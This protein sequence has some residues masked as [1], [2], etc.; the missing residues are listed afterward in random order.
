MGR[1]GSPLSDPLTIVGLT[2]TWGGL[3][4]RLALVLVG[5]GRASGL[6]RVVVVRGVV[7]GWRG[8]LR[9][10]RWRTNVSGTISTNTTWTTSGSPYVLTVMIR[11][12]ALNFT[13]TP[14]LIVN[15]TPEEIETLPVS[16]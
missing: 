10:R 11:D 3:G 7:G 2:S 8:W 12:D 6:V 14:E 4:G 5:A 15:V 9:G 13:T 1:L 16:T